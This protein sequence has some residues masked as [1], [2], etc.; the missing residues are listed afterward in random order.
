RS[1]EIVEARAEADRGVPIRA[2][3]VHVV[4]ARAAVVPELRRSSHER[5]VHARRPTRGDRDANVLH[6]DTGRP[7]P[8][9]RDLEARDALASAAE[10]ARTAALAAGTGDEARLVRLLRRPD[11][12]GAAAG[13]GDRPGDALALRCLV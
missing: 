3:H 13:L 10:L 6:R 11:Q 12:E 2:L 9:E 5:A 8:R 7:S 4:A 1:R